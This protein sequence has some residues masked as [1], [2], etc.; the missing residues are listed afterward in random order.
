[1]DENRVIARLNAAI[2]NLLSAINISGTG[3][4]RIKLDIPESDLPELMKLAA[5]GS[6]KLLWITVELAD[7]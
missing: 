5:L 1:M 6:E 2:P 4:G 3:S 7:E